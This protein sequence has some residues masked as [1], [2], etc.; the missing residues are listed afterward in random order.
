LA[1]ALSDQLLGDIEVAL[2]EPVLLE[3]VAPAPRRDL[4]IQSID[5]ISRIS[6]QKA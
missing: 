1:P 3:E 2:A 4:K 6:S 5:L